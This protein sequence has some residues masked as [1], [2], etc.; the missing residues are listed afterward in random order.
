[1]SDLMKLMDA[2]ANASRHEVWRPLDVTSESMALQAA[3]AALAAAGYA[4][5]P[6]EPTEEMMDAGEAQDR[7]AAPW[8]SYSTEHARCEDHYAAMIA[9][10]EVKP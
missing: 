9:V 3:L 2:A 4:I 10:G 8:S 1:M 5:V 6:K 7:P